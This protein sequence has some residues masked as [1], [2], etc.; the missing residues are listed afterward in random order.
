M[1]EQQII[2]YF[3]SVEK[4]DDFDFHK[5]CEENN[6]DVHEAESKVYEMLSS[7]I[8]SGNYKKLDFDTIDIKEFQMGIKVEMEHTNNI[9]FAAKI[10][11]DHLQEDSKYYTRLLEAKL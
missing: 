11:L 4:V 8:N 3:M 1:L 10:V 9:F 7:F 2:K 5:F 6:I